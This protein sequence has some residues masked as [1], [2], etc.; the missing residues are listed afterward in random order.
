VASGLRYFST[1]FAW[2]ITETAFPVA[3]LPRD[4]MTTQPAMPTGLLALEGYEV[5]AIGDII[6]LALDVVRLVKA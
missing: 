2:L 5:D 3:P 6:T 1:G 4:S